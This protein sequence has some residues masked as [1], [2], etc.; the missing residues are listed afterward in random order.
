M[1]CLGRLVVLF[2]LL[3]GLI[4]FLSFEFGSRTPGDA[5]PRSATPEHNAA[6]PVVA[7]VP[8]P[9]PAP[10]KSSEDVPA[11]SLAAE[12]NQIP[13]LVALADAKTKAERAAD[14]LVKARE[15][16]SLRLAEH[17]EEYKAAKAEAD[18][19]HQ[20]LLA[21]RDSG[22]PIETRLNEGAMMNASRQKLQKLEKAAADAD[23]GVAAAQRDLA[24]AQAEELKCKEA[25]AAHDAVLADR[26]NRIRQAA[27][28]I[29]ALAVGRVGLLSAFRI[30]QVVDKGSA[31]VMPE[32]HPEITLLLTGYNMSDAADGQLKQ[33]SDPVRITRTQS[34]ESLLG[35]RTVLVAE[36]YS[37]D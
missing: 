23:P 26:L 28:P 18:Q 25:V 36:P 30:I 12:P 16:A 32:D 8:A 35:R 27:Q 29:G 15:A 7:A 4:V 14:A 5:Q 13:P 21:A 10:D 6:T 11:S 34:Y 2:V 22:A 31:L 9:A 19:H 3:V 17:S 20:A 33:L 24:S 1:A 37:D